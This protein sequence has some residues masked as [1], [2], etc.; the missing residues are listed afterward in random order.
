MKLDRFAAAVSLALV[1]AAPVFSQESKPAPAAP[2][3]TQPTPAADDGTDPAVKRNTGSYNLA[4][5]KS[6][7][8]IEGYDPVAYFPEGG[9]KATKGT[10]TH[11]FTYRGVV[12]WFASQKNLDEFTKDPR[13]YEPAYGGWCAYAMGATGEKVEIDPKSFTI[14]DGQLFLFYKDLFTDTRSKW[15]KDTA[16][17]HPKA[18]KN[19]KKISGEDAPAKSE[20]KPDKK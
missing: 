15:N 9:G 7:P 20:S 12:Y 19:W 10:K 13:K 8:A 1:V 16:N 2:G 14:T 3:S 4:K 17:L 18:D 11:S 6:K 5:D